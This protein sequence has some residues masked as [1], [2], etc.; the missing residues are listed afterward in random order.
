MIKRKLKIFSHPW[1]VSHQYE[2]SKLPNCQFY[3]CV[4][5]TRRW[6][7]MARPFPKERIKWVPYFEK[8]KYDLAILH[9]DMQCIDPN[10]GKAVLF[11]QLLSEVKKDDI[12]IIIVN[13][14]TTCWPE[15]YTSGFIRARMKEIVG[16]LPMV[17]NSYQ[18]Q[19]DWGEE[20]NGRTIIHGLDPD[21]WW[22]DLPKEPRVITFISAAG[23]DTY[24]NRQGLSAVKQILAEEYGINLVW[25]GR[26]IKIKDFDMWRDILGR[27]LIYYNPTFASPM[28]RSRTEAQMSGCCIVTTPNQ[29]ADRF[30]KH[31]ENGFL[32]KWNDPYGTAELINDLIK[33]RYREAVEIGQKGRKTAEKDFHIKRYQKE[34]LDLINSVL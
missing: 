10:I 4:N 33:N 3:Y 20:F 13:H 1:H 30:I 15:G 26:D 6:A 12:P 24:Y 11:R 7:E 17:F 18:A 31:G 22:A 8:G 23:W 25:I 5:H 27:S 14:S 29:D 16:D 2:L 34:W 19:K 32:V 28:P 9:C 21:E